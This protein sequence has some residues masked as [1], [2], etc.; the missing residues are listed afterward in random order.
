MME[1]YEKSPTRVDLA[2]GTLDCWPLYLFL[3]NP[4]TINVAID[5]FTHC[6]LRPRGDAKIEIHSEDLGLS[7]EFSNLD[8]CLENQDPELEMYRAQFR[9]WRP[10][11]GF[12]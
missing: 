1:I 2:G 6:T 12:S 7:R 8:A 4:L 5:I 10:A 11:S 3:D 9:Y